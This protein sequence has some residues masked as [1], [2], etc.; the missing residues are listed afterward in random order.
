MRRPIVYYMLT[1]RGTWW[2]PE[3]SSHYAKELSR[4]GSVVYF[5]QGS[6]REEAFRQTFRHLE[7]L[8][9]VIADP[10]PE[11]LADTEYYF[12]SAKHEPGI[13]ADQASSVLD[14]S[15]ACDGN[16]E[17]DCRR[18]AKVVR[19]V[20]HA[21]RKS[22]ALDIA[23]IPGINPPRLHLLSARARDLLS[24][25]GATGCSITPALDKSTG[26]LSTT[27]FQLHVTQ[28]V[29]AP[30]D[31]GKVLRIID[32]CPRCGAVLAGHLESLPVFKRDE[33]AKTDFQYFDAYRTSNRGEI[34]LVNEIPLVSG[35]VMKALVASGMSG[36]R[37][38]LTEPPIRF[39]VAEIT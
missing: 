2:P 22:K 14:L 7:L 23:A 4:F 36:L 8:R 35:R 12:L 20:V 1:Q 29:S 9:H 16:G 37:D 17:V 15:A 28:P 3:V 34:K 18:G 21:A 19:P 6:E 30:P 32:E 31:S 11:E 33:M 24:S 13:W 27:R 10:S 39:G 25:L 38:Y 26:A 5:R